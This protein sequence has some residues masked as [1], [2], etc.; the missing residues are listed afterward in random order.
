MCSLILILT[1]HEKERQVALSRITYPLRCGH[2]KLVWTSL[3]PGYC[4]GQCYNIVI[5]LTPDMASPHSRKGHTCLV[6]VLS[7]VLYGGDHSLSTLASELYAALSQ[8]WV[9][10]PHYCLLNPAQELPQQPTW[11][12]GNSHCPP[13]PFSH[14][15]ASVLCCSPVTQTVLASA[16]ANP[17]PCSSDLLPSYV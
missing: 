2:H 8:N 4:T 12:S 10:A 17:A 14:T 11:L 6:K 9:A 5:P 15:P 3:C 13:R 1:L 7:S 16:S